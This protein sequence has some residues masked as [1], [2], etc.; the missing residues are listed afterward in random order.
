MKITKSCMEA[1]MASRMIR[2]DVQREHIR[3]ALENPINTELVK[4]LES[5][6]GDKAK[7][8]LSAAKA[9]IA[10][11]VA[12]K[13]DAREAEEMEETQVMNTDAQMTAPAGRSMPT[14]EMRRPPVP[15]IETPDLPGDFESSDDESEPEVD[16]SSKV[17][18]KKI[19]ASSA[20]KLSKLIDTTVEIKCLLNEKDT[21]SGVIRAAVKE[22]ELW[23]YYNDSTNLNTVMGDV[24]DA[25][26]NP[27]P[28][29]AF[30]RLART[31][32]AMV[33]VLDFVN[34][35]NTEQEASAE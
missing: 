10:K 1:V 34:Q 3:A 13:K 17:R 31:D 4:Q 35:Y 26:A 28:W 27:Y 19:T 25:L 12:D 7:E 21:T 30:N 2:S 15:D 9:E 23:V 6:L 32:N 11:K 16:S 33:F 8:E 18:G 24:I 20:V 14:I 5:Y 22:D 29:L